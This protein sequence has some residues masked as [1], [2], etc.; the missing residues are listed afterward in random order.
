MH[1][2][3]TNIIIYPDEAGKFIYIRLF[4]DAIFCLGLSR[5]CNLMDDLCCLS[6]VFGFFI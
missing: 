4:M 6:T 5:R 1:Y 3:N 2:I